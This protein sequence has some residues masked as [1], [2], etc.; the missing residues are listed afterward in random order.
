MIGLRRLQQRLD[1]KTK[2]RFC[3]EGEEKDAWE[4]L[5]MNQIRSL[6][7]MRGML[8][9]NSLG[10]TAEHLLL[11]AR[12]RVSLYQIAS[13]C[14]RI[15]LFDK[16][17]ISLEVWAAVTSKVW[18]DSGRASFPPPRSKR[19]KKEALFV[20]CCNQTFLTQWNIM[21]TSTQ[22]HYLK[23]SN[24]HCVVKICWG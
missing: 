24:L 7:S 18:R 22:T 8:L 19:Q 1:V 2:G 11:R 14:T 6:L 3:S 21:L 15:N 17:L 4:R 9:G 20:G 16:R 13:T 12:L 23:Y 5:C 10:L